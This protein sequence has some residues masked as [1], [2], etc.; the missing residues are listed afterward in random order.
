MLALTEGRLAMKKLTKRLMSL[1]AQRD[2]ARYA[3][4]FKQLRRIDRLILKLRLMTC[5]ETW[6]EQTCQSGDKYPIPGM[7]LCRAEVRLGLSTL[8]GR[9]WTPRDAADWEDRA[10]ITGKVFYPSS[11][12]SIV[13]QA[14]IRRGYIQPLPSD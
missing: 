5:S 1:N 8:K 6:Y 9:R 14:D 3:K 4:D 13:T 2:R 10:D 11:V 7:V 12:G